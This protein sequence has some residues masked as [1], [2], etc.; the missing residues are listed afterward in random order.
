MGTYSSAASALDDAARRANV[1]EDAWHELA[2]GRQIWHAVD[3]VYQYTL[4]SFTAPAA[5]LPPLDSV[6]VQPTA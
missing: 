4:E 6:E 5:A 1:P 3:G 2:P